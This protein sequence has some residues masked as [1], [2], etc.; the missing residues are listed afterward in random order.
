M[1]NAIGKTGKFQ[2]IFMVAF[3]AIL[4]KQGLNSYQVLAEKALAQEAVTQSVQLWK[5]SYLALT[6]AVKQ[7]SNDYHR[8]D[9]VQ[10]LISLYQ[11]VDF[12]QYGLQVETDSLALNKV[13]PVLKEGMEIGLTKICLT[14]SVS[15]GSPS[16]EVKAP[17]YQAL[18]SGLN[19]L[20]NRKDIFIATIEV[21]GAKPTPVA[22]LGEF[23]VLMRRS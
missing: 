1:I 19:A 23:C 17:N 16:L 7:W 13:E 10:D 12:A 20:A 15:G 18:F 8:E 21:E 22:R 4:V 3:A 11:V 6:G 14:S 9:S 2:L 5:Q